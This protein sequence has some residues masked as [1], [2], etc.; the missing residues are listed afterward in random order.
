MNFINMKYFSELQKWVNEKKLD[1]ESYE[2]ISVLYK[3]EKNPNESLSKDAQKT[4]FKR[5]SLSLRW[6]KG[7]TVGRLPILTDVDIDILKEHIT[8][9]A[10]DGEY[11]DVEYAVEI[12]DILRNDRIENAISFLQHIK[13]YGICDEIRDFSRSN[14][15]GRSWVYQHLHDLETELRTPKNVEINRI[16]A[17]TPEKIGIFCETFLPIVDEIPPPLR[18]GA[19]ETMLAPVITR[20]VL[21]P[22]NFP[23]PIVPESLPMPHITAMCCA[24]VFG[25]KMPLFIILPNL[26]KTP[27]ELIGFQER[28]QAIFASSNNG[29]QTRDSFLWFAICFI[30][31]LSFYRKKL[32]ENIRDKKA[33]LIVDGHKS[34]EC[35]IAIQLLKQHNIELFVLPAHTSHITQMFDVGIGSPMKATFSDHFNKLMQ[36]FNP[37]LNQIAQIRQFCIHAAILAWDVKANFKSCA[38]AALLTGTHPCSDEF[39]R[40][41]I[42]VREVPAHLQQFLSEKKK[43]QRTE[44]LNINNKLISDDEV[45]EE[46]NEFIRT[47]PKHSYLCTENYNGIYSELIPIICRETHNDCH[48]LGSIP[49]YIDEESH[50]HCF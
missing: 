34:R 7:M 2:R 41:T 20:K 17:C 47:R 42:F 12:A 22:Q 29:W 23:G 28:G 32:N 10:I 21:V 46:I 37:Q 26:V 36:N 43:R 11:I 39:L 49:P 13:C 48:F 50:V 27:E 38:K 24:N 6:E 9:N 35:P 15:T 1:N 19:D 40:E 33:L 4:C 3:I 25:E 45:Y 14:E 31:Y 5:S 30:N 8:E 18:F 44:T 16:L